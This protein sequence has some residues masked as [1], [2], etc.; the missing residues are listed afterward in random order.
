[1]KKGN[2]GD[3]KGDFSII[4]SIPW[5]NLHFISSKYKNMKLT[6]FV[7]YETKS[8]MNWSIT[9]NECTRKYFK[10]DFISNFDLHSNGRKKN[11]MLVYSSTL[12]ND[13]ICSNIIII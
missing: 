5:D 12:N 7:D 2:S 13:N 3:Y 1:M 6:W 8:R 10:Y 11:T 4:I 9:F